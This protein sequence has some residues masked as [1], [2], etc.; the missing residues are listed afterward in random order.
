MSESRSNPNDA[1]IDQCHHV[2]N[3][4]WARRVISMI[5]HLGLKNGRLNFN[6]S[7]NNAAILK[8]RLYEQNV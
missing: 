1:Y 7:V 4:C 3:A 2:C 6:A 8:T 5:D